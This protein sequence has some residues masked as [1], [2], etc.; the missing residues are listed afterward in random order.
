MTNGVGPASHPAASEAA[1]D[2]WVAAHPDG[3]ILSVTDAFD[4]S[5]TACE[6]LGWLVPGTTGR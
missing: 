5:R 1:A 2:A 6:D 4:N 3:E